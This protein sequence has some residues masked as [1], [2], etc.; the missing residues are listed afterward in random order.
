MTTQQ[1]PAIKII[2]AF[3]AI[4][5]VWGS[6]FFAVH[7]ALKSFPAFLLSALRFLLTGTILLLY[8]I[9]RREKIPS[10][11]DIQKNALCGLVL[12]IGGVVSVAWAQ[13]YIS[14]IIIT[15]P[16]VCIAR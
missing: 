10:R 4:Y 13:Q 9:I 8:C 3:A 2:L 1:L 7:V 11:I 5:I 14:S 16:L 12:F 6:T 15:T